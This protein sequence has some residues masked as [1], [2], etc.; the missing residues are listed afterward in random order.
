MVHFNLERFPGLICCADVVAERKRSAQE[1]AQAV[2]VKVDPLV[3]LCKVKR[4][5]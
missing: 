1:R 2:G 5:L 4:A 3:V